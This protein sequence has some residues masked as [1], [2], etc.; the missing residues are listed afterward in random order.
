MKKYSGFTQEPFPVKASRKNN[1]IVKDTNTDMDTDD[2][3]ESDLKID[4]DIKSYTEDNNN[5]VIDSDTGTGLEKVSV[6]PGINLTLPL[7]VIE[8]N[9]HSVDESDNTEE[10]SND[11]KEAVNETEQDLQNRGLLEKLIIKSHEI[12]ESETTEI[13]KSA[14]ATFDSEVEG[15][16]KLP[17]NNESLSSSLPSNKEDLCVPD[18]LNIK[19]PVISEILDSAVAADLSNSSA[20]SPASTTS[21]NLISQTEKPKAPYKGTMVPCGNLKDYLDSLP[22]FNRKCMLR[23]GREVHKI[24]VEMTKGETFLDD[25]FAYTEFGRMVLTNGSIRAGRA[26]NAK[27]IVVARETLYCSGTS[28]CKRACGG[29]GICLPG[30]SH[31]SSF[32]FIN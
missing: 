28:A 23:K 3:S 4:L 14:V 21:N 30:K 1:A 11:T 7:S 29:Y 18:A 9:G 26:K 24:Y 13:T 12:G 32:I 19:L 22:T 2:G 25:Q 27:Q 15:K 17:V 10:D 31:F 6:C 8:E 16:D 5:D 20:H